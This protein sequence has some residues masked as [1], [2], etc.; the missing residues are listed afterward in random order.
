M[1]ERVL[2]MMQY[3]YG[4]WTLI[5]ERIKVIGDKVSMEMFYLCIVP[6]AVFNLRSS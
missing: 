6:L 5:R 1:T 3:Y 2:V 4:L